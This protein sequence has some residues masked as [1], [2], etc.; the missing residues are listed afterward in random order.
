MD[1]DQERAGAAMKRGAHRED[2]AWRDDQQ[3]AR[4]D[5]EA[6][7]EERFAGGQPAPRRLYGEGTGVHPRGAAGFDMGGEDAGGR[8]RPYE[9]GPPPALSGGPARDYGPAGLGDPGYGHWDYRL[10]NRRGG[11]ARNYGERQSNAYR[12][13]RGFEETDPYYDHTLARARE[14]G[15]LPAPDRGEPWEVPGPMTGR[16]PRGY[17]RGD[18][19][20]FE[21]INDRLT[22]HGDIDATGIEVKVE[23]GEVILAGSV[24][25][26][27]QKRL[28]EDIAFSVPGV[29]DVRTRLTL[30]QG[31]RQA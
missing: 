29:R 19:L 13:P 10:G 15:E 21:D 17:H 6:A 2:D 27:E 5:D 16:G 31:D 4:L 20:I 11:Y 14:R 28:A 12:D 26:R 3:D 25:T 9:P 8:P 7:Y 1:E 22:D 30:A 18:R 23:N 24:A